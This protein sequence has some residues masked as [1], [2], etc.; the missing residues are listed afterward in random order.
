MATD[1]LSRSRRVGTL[2]THAET[3]PRLNALVNDDGL[4]SAVG[5]GLWLHRLRGAAAVRPE[6][7]RLPIAH[8]GRWLLFLG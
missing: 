7:G 2:R 1:L 5:A 4:A 8:G 3:L 6:L